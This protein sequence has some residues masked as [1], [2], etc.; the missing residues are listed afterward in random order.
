ME[1][2]NNY[3]SKLNWK[4]IWN[5]FLDLI[6]ILFFTMLASVIPFI[7]MLVNSDNKINWEILYNNGNFFLY[8][9]SLLSS[10][11]IHFLHKSQFQ[12]IKY[13]LLIL[14]TICAISY[15]QLINNTSSSSYTKYGS[16]IFPL[17]AS[18]IFLTAQYQQRLELIDVNQID[19]NQQ[20]QLASRITF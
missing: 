1:I 19:Q 10:S 2:F 14:I 20:D 5:S 16:I 11:L 8:S 18:I 17:V 12:F 4:T 7:A 9:I 13:L 3:L 6:L 15:S